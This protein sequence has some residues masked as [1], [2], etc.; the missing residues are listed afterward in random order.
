[1]DLPQYDK[2]YS[3]IG[4]LADKA[5]S[6]KSYMILGLIAENEKPQNVM[7]RVNVFSEA[8]YIE[9]TSE[10]LEH[11]GVN[12]IV[13]PFSIIDQWTHY[14][15]AFDPDTHFFV[16]NTNKSFLHYKSHIKDTHDIVLVSS[17]FYYM[18]QNQFKEMNVM[19]SRVIFDEADS[20]ITKNAKKLPALFYWFVS[21]S[22]NN[23]INPYPKYVA[24]LNSQ[25]TRYVNR[26]VSSGVC[27]NVFIKSLFGSLMRSLPH[28]DKVVLEKLIVKNSDSFVSNSFS[29]PE[30]EEFY[31]RCV[32]TI[33]ELVNCM[34]TNQNIINCVNAGDLITA[35]SYL[36]RANKGN[37]THIIDILKDDLNKQLINCRL[38]I[39]YQ[40]ELIVDD[41][42]TQTNKINQLKSREEAILLKINLMEERIKHGDLCTICYSNFTNKTVVR[43]CKNAFC[44]ECICTWLQVRNTCPICKQ[45]LPDIHNDLFVI[46]D[47]E[48]SCSSSSDNTSLI[49]KKQEALIKLITHIKK[50]RTNGKILVFSEYERPFVDV[51]PALD[52]TNINY[53]MLKGSSLKGN[54]QRYKNTE[55]DILLINS[56]AFGSGINLENT[57]DIVIYHSFNKEIQSQV[58]GRAQR[59]GRTSPLKV[60]YLL[61]NSEL[62][63]NPPSEKMTEYDLQKQCITI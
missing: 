62:E 14:I 37:E 21:A 2:A 17:S 13:C 27:N 55:L 59:P 25:G 7:R 46:K 24:T 40:S 1:V 6:G 60:W 8:I 39:K 35:M 56:K 53:G 61:N 38:K 50:I 63:K 49:Y 30:I 42:E 19:V 11:L 29:L 12:V 54:I 57:T 36:N 31:I 18:V 9:H 16:V 22:Y 26:L 32:D 34:T 51:M 15:N 10:T 48:T 20:A 5:G 58:I 3:N 28:R 52:D 23:V 4:I 45:E 33:S 43:C 44:F 41:T 47:N